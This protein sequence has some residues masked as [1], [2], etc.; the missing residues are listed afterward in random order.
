[1][2]LIFAPRA[3]SNAALTQNITAHDNFDFLSPLWLELTSSRIFTNVKFQFHF[4]TGSKFKTLG[5]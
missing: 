5:L 3:T 4:W 1:M 2:I